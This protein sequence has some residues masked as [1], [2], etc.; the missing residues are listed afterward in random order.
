[1]SRRADAAQ[2]DLVA[3]LRQQGEVEL[4]SLARGLA[5]EDVQCGHAHV[6]LGPGLRGGAQAC[7]HRPGGQLGQ[8][9]ESQGTHPVHARSER[10]QAA[11]QDVLSARAVAFRAR[12]N[13]THRREPVQ[14]RTRGSEGSD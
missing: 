12:Q 13:G 6:A 4:E 1:L 14:G 3:G 5:S 7:A 11:H 2:L 8:R 10:D 9:L